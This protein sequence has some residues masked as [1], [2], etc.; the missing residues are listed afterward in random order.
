[1]TSDLA[2]G[3]QKAAIAGAQKHL[4]LCLG[5]ECCE[6]AEGEALWEFAKQRVRELNLPV[7]RTKAGCF[8]ICTEGPWLVVY[9]DGTWYS[10]VTPER[11]ER[12]LQEHVIGGAPV[13]E[14]VVATNTLS[15]PGA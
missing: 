10:R 15:R 12:I 5:P 6:T 4:F 14:W 13:A 1:M 11:L 3:I 8:R 2:Q 7:M 9:P